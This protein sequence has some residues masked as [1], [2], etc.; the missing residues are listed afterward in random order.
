MPFSK[1][2][3]NP[4]FLSDSTSIDISHLSSTTAASN[5]PDLHCSVSDST[6][7]TRRGSNESDNKPL[8]EKILDEFLEFSVADPS[9]STDGMLY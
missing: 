6:T 1:I 4:L 3:K 5:I 8:S 2:I 9:D 7:S